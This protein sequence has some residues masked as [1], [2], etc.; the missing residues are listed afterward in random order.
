M[1]HTQLN[2]DRLRWASLSVGFMLASWR[3]AWCSTQSS[4]TSD[5][6]LKQAT[7]RSTHHPSDFVLQH[8]IDKHKRLKSPLYLCF[9][10]L[11]SAYDRVQWHV[12]VVCH[13][14][15]VCLYTFQN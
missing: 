15:M 14:G 9:V 7:G 10:D 6:P 13:V 11:K 1:L 4:K 8:V 5:L 3:S 2:T 12:G